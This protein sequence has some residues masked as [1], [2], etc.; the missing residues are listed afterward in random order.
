[1]ISQILA[2]SCSGR[3]DDLFTEKL[4]ELHTTF[5]RKKVKAFNFSNFQLVD[6]STTWSTSL[7][8]RCWYQMLTIVEK[9]QYLKTFF[10]PCPNI[11]YQTSCYFIKRK[12]CQYKYLDEIS[13]SFPLIKYGCYILSSSSSVSSVPGRWDNFKYFQRSLTSPAEALD[14]CNASYLR[15]TSRPYTVVTATDETASKIKLP[16]YFQI[17]SICAWRIFSRSPLGHNVSSNIFVFGIF[18]QCSFSW[19]KK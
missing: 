13:K 3:T 11:L 1:M 16:E 4:H 15:S 18:S 8:I 7:I 14:G 9:Q 17:S 10:C 2:N 12:V 19:L 6:N 5:H